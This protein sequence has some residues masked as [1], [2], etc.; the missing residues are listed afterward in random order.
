MCC[1]HTNPPRIDQ[2]THG[3]ENPGNTEYKSRRPIIK[4]FCILGLTNF[5]SHSQEYR[6]TMENSEY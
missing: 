3:K 6:I 2:N 1:I 5:K 4:N